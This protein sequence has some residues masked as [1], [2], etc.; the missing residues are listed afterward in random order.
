MLPVNADNV[1]ESD[2]KLEK[3]LWIVVKQIKTGNLFLLE[4]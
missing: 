3:K 2:Q 1:L 4:F